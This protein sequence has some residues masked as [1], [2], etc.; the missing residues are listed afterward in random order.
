M[1]ARNETTEWKHGMEQRN[2]AT[3]K[4]NGM[5]EGTRKAKLEDA[6]KMLQKGID[7][8]SIVEITGLSED[9]INKIRY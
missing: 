9:E 4:S 6:K 1:K 7:I 2:K 3:A 8:K 5:Q